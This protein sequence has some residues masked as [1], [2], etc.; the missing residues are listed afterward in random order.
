MSINFD[1][2]L[3]AARG[4]GAV[5]RRKA[6]TVGSTPSLRTIA[7]PHRRRHPTARGSTNWATGIVPDCRNFRRWCTPSSQARPAATPCAVPRS[8]RTATPNRSASSLAAAHR[9]PK[10]NNNN[11]NTP[12]YDSRTPQSGMDPWHQQL[13]RNIN[14]FLT[15]ADIIAAVRQPEQRRAGKPTGIPRA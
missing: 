6:G 13:R 4:F 7:R 2:N 9:A 15:V 10:L 1:L 3:Q 12:A 8:I 11:F 5:S 14:R